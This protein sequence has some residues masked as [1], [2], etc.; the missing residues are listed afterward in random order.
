MQ[1]E[2]IHVDLGFIDWAK[3]QIELYAEMF[4]KQVY[5]SDVDQPTIDEALKITH[6]QSRKV[7]L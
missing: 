3:K 1:E 6:S 5:S 2:V 7:W 4:K